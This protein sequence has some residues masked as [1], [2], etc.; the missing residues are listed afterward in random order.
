MNRTRLSRT[1]SVCTLAGAALA[2]ASLPASAQDVAS[3]YKSTTLTVLVG[4]GA[5][6]GYDVFT[7]VMVRTF[8]KHIPG[9]PRIVVQNMPGAAGIKALNHLY[10]IAPKDGS[11]IESTYNTLPLDPLFGGQGEKYDPRKLSWIGS[12]AKQIN[13]CLA[14][15][16]SSFKTFDDVYKR[17][18]TLAS[19]GAAGWRS[20]LPK[21]M[22]NLTG[23]KFKVI[24]GY[25][26][27]G[28]IPA[29]E[30]GEVDG[31]CTTYQTMQ[32]TAPD[33]INHHKVVFLA[34][35]G[36]KPIPEIKD[37]EMGLNRV[38]DP[39]D[40]KAVRLV[41]VQQEYGRPYVAPPGMPA[42][43]LAAL[44]AAFDQT[45]ADPQ[46][47]ADAKRAGMTIEPV[48]GQ[49]MAKIVAD[50]YHA[51]KELIQRAKDILKRAGSK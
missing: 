28:M 6:G 37:V 19:S 36:E 30:K 42:D 47:A 11:V 2:L 13:V 38:K 21:M 33:W 31:M 5:G 23:S 35:F 27:S 43:R 3:F 18:M 51:P 45:M 24:E 12:I 34:Q 4:S 32:A 25:E 26:T 41:L 10:S 22:N 14:W 9:N 48:T 46:F 15:G 49:E 50:A 8:P 39:E 44:R 29:V 16:Q 20:I 7:R 17:Q 40:L 1:A